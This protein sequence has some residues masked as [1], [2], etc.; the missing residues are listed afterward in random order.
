MIRRLGNFVDLFCVLL[1]IKQLDQSSKSVSGTPANT[2]RRLG[3]FCVCG[4][5]GRSF[6]L[7]SVTRFE[8]VD[9]DSRNTWT[10]IVTTGTEH[11]MF[12]SLSLRNTEYAGWLDHPTC[13]GTILCDALVEEVCIAGQQVADHLDICASL[14]PF[15]DFFRP[16]QFR[17]QNSPKNESIL[18]ERSLLQQ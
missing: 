6:S 13:L 3:D 17:H 10:G 15:N 11:V 18:F 12:E 9:Y 7:K 14:P 4:G 16:R 8:A 2:S 5:R 1:D